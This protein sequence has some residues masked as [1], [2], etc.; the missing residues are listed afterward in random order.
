MGQSL[1]QSIRRKKGEEIYLPDPSHLRSSTTLSLPFRDS[2]PSQ[3]QVAL[4]SPCSSCT[5]CQV[6]HLQSESRSARRHKGFQACCWLTSSSLIRGSAQSQTAA[7]VGME[8][9]IR[10]SGDRE[11]KR[12]E[13]GH[14]MCL[15][16]SSTCSPISARKPL[17]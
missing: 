8:Q 10:A 7:E 3:P 9:V 2:A 4:L 11:A 1:V 6:S 15:I 16:Y 12:S 13:A 14:K 17:V 5:G